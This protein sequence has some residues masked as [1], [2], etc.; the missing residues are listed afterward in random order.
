MNRPSRARKYS[1]LYQ[2]YFSNTL[3]WCHRRFHI[4]RLEKW[5]FTQV[6]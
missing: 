4:S 5:D 3:Y 6:L 1:K 2:L